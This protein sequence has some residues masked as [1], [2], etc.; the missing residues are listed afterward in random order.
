MTGLEAVALAAAVAA[1]VVVFVGLPERLYRDAQ[2]HRWLLEQERRA[3]RIDADRRIVS[4]DEPL[5]PGVTL[6]EAYRVSADQG[7][8]L[9]DAAFEIH[10][11]RTLA[12]IRK[13]VRTP[14][15]G[16]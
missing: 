6:D 9:A 3:R 11:A 1:A 16:D 7:I 14:R 13:A 12:V 2:H 4:G 15:P 8:T 10:R 5:P